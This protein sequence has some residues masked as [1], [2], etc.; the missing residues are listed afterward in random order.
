MNDYIFARPSILEGFA[1]IA[2]LGG[3]LQKYRRSPTPD[4]ADSK[5]IYSDFKAVGDDIRRAMDQFD[6]GQNAGERI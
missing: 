1:R 4:Q 6:G 2:D 5:A 3:T